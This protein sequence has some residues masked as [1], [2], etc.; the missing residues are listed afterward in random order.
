MAQIGLQATEVRYVVRCAKLIMGY[1]HLEEQGSIG[2]NS[3]DLSI[4]G[5][6]AAAEKLARRNAGSATGLIEVK[7]CEFGQ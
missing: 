2:H 4:D 7:E 1:R 6:H 3:H 5:A